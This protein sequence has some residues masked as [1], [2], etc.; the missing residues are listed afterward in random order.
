MGPSSS[1]RLANFFALFASGVGT[2]DEMVTSYG[3]LAGGSK[4]ILSAH[5][6]AA[7]YTS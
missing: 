2:S 1:I 7:L 6:L 4:G 3:P 5:T